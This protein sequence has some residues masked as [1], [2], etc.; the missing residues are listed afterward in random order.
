MLPQHQSEKVD[1][2]YLSQEVFQIYIR[3]K[4]KMREQLV[5]TIYK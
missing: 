3:M 1:Q 5:R 2:H 4:K